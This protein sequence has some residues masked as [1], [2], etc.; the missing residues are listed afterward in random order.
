MKQVVMAPIGLRA[1][2]KQKLA[3]LRFYPLFAQ[4]RLRM[5]VK[6][7][8]ENKKKILF[9][10]D[11]D[12]LYRDADNMGRY[13]FFIMNIF[14]ESGYAVFF[15]KKVDFKFYISMGRYG[16]DIY[17]IKNLKIVERFPENP[18][19]TIFAFDNEVIGFKILEKEWKRRVYINVLKDGAWK[20]E[21]CSWIPYA[22]HFLVYK[23][24]AHLKL[25]RYRKSTK[26]MR[27]FFGGNTAPAYYNNPLLMSHYGQLSR[28]MALNIITGSEAVNKRYIKKADELLKRIS[29]GQPDNSITLFESGGSGLDPSRWLDV[30]SSA[31]FFL[32]LSGTDYPMCHNAIEAMAV[33]A[34]PLLSYADWFFPP[35]EHG[36]N[37]LIFHGKDDLVKTIESALQ[38][39]VAD[40]TR[41]RAKVIEYYEKHL[42]FQSFIK[43]F[44]STEEKLSTLAL[45]P[46]YVCTDADKKENPQANFEELA[47]NLGKLR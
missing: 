4:E 10:L 3:K 37:A 24:G 26:K 12:R 45:H 8:P 2:V 21:P 42:S 31:D 40:I 23:N 19:D 43:K 34:I 18:S 44:E 20:F 13:A 47:S 22:M 36:E 41:M 16:R 38:M 7:L 33:G 29:D 11:Y 5:A 46:R 39:S 9:V 32:C 1:R 30:V 17:R 6:R 27:I 15:Y 14:S 35:L 25:D 28:L